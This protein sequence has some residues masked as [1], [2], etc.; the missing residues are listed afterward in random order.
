MTAGGAEGGGAW[1]TTSS[2]GR[3]CCR[4]GRQGTLRA[5]T[6]GDAAGCDSRLLIVMAGVLWVVTAGDTVA[7]P[8]RGRCGVW[9]VTAGTYGREQ[10]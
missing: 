7:R 8:S 6:A 2:D 3:R 5:V 9:W 10:G 1:D 4:H